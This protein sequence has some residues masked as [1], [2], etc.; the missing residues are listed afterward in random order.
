MEKKWYSQW[1]QQLRPLATGKFGHVYLAREKNGTPSSSFVLRH[2]KNSFIKCI[3]N[4]WYLTY[5]GFFLPTNILYS[6]FNF[7][8]V[9]DIYIKTDLKKEK[10]TVDSTSEILQDDPTTNF[11]ILLLKISNIYVK[12]SFWKN[13]RAEYDA[14]WSSIIFPASEYSS[15]PCFVKYCMFFTLIV[16]IIRNILAINIFVIALVCLL[17]NVKFIIR[18]WL[19]ALYVKRDM[20]PNI[21]PLF[22]CQCLFYLRKNPKNYEGKNLLG[23]QNF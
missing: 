15:S 11:V 13:F 7:M 23:F 16:I 2:F 21:K 18:V 10:E 3:L 17:C 12:K 5:I 6:I 19:F 4:S 14:A 22:I 9:I 8:I 20:A 1:L